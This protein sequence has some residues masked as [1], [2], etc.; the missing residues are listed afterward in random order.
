[1]MSGLESRAVKMAWKHLCKKCGCSSF[2]L[3]KMG[4]VVCTVKKKSFLSRKD[5][6]VLFGSL[7]ALGPKICESS[8][9]LPL[10]DENGKEMRHWMDAPYKRCLEK[11]R[12][13]ADSLEC[14]KQIIDFL[15]SQAKDADIFMYGYSPVSGNLSPVR[16][17]DSGQTLEEM[18]VTLDLEEA[19]LENN[20]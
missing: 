16:V 13:K 15:F 6:Q 19:E 5:K 3:D 14:K 17:I 11:F 9:F 4:R 1:M 20:G 18:C 10:V 8:L 12:S 2:T 7:S